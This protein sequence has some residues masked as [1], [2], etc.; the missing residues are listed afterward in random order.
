MD[1]RIRDRIVTHALKASALVALS[2]VSVAALGHYVLDLDAWGQV[3]LA[4]L[5]WGVG[6]LRFAYTLDPQ[7]LDES[8]L[9]FEHWLNRTAIRETNLLMRLGFFLSSVVLW[10]WQGAAVLLASWTWKVYLCPTPYSNM[11]TSEERAALYS[12]FSA[13]EL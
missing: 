4:A 9:K 8:N 7:E 10:P 2:A 11:L 3:G 1:K 6:G 5:T 13:E 12:T